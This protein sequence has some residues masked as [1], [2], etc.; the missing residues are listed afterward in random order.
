MAKSNEGKRLANADYWRGRA[1]STKNISM[2][3]AEAFIE[4]MEKQYRVASRNIELEVNAFLSRFAEN[5]QIT[6]N[7]AQKMLKADEL[8]KFKMD[9]EEYIKKGQENGVSVDWTKQLESA[10]DLHRMD[11]LSALKLQIDNQIETLAAYKER[12]LNKTLGDIF[13]ESYYRNIFDVQQHT[14]RGTAFSILD[15]RKIKQAISKPWRYDGKTFSDSIWE[16]K[17]KLKYS[18][19]KTLTQSIIRGSTPQKIAEA[20]AKE[21]GSELYAA[22]RLVLT[23][24]AK[25]AE[26]ASEEGY[27]ELGVEEI[28]IVVSVDEKTCEVC[29]EMDG[30]HFPLSKADGLTPPFHPNCRCT[31]VPY[32]DDEF[33]KGESRAARG[34]D[35]K[36]Y[37]VPADMKYEEW[38]KT[39]VDGGKSSLKEISESGI[40][41]KRTPKQDEY[42]INREVIDSNEYKKKFNGITNKPKVDKAIHKYA[43]AALYHRDGTNREDLYILSSSTGDILG[44]NITST[45]SFGVPVNDS[46]RKAILNHQGDLIGMHTHFDDTPPT[47]S[48]FETAFKRRY[49]L[50]VVANATGDIYLY[51]CGDQYISA[52]LIDD[53]IEKY[54]KLVDENGKKIYNTTKEAHL[55]A[56]SQL[57]KDY[58]IWY[59]AR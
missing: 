58:G 36:T 27:K 29:G 46:V 19:E 44:K 24:G 25:M 34:K 59:E 38:K 5:E 50:G 28:E 57:G 23:E 11:R 45:E 7:D 40:T 43:K 51:G 1:E 30:K 18:L 20:I 15:D 41:N 21:T 42:K 54:I 52:K 2:M 49:N 55:Q 26:A 10:S 35:G 6:L 12:G 8:K 13:E 32:F 14:G 17:E 37:Y 16:D 48:D 56:L 3:K 33:T 9:V 53:T 4:D 22:K 47:G 31:T 39:F